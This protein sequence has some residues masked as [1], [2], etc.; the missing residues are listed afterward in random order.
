MNKENTSDVT[1]LVPAGLLP[2]DIM[3]AAHRLAVQYDFRIYLSN[4]QNLR[5]INVPDEVVTSVKDELAKLGAAFKAPG[6]FPIPRVCI[7]EGH[8][9]LG[10]V[11]TFQVSQKILDAFAQ[12]KHTKAKFKIAV[13]GCTMSCADAKT[14]DIG[15]IAKRKGYDLFAGGKGG[16]FPKT[17]RRIAKNVND[18]EMLNVIETLVEFH[19]SKTEKKQRMSKLLDDPAFPFPEV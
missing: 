7:G 4:A 8:C 15:I 5:L 14:T 3:E 1:I 2:L 9:K 11:D 6:K 10:V 19:D 13:A 18:A 16:A 12:R 17:G